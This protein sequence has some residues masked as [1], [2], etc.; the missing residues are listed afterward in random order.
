M[1]LSSSTF[2]LM[3]E[4]AF[5]AIAMAAV[6]AFGVPFLLERG[7]VSPALLMRWSW[8]AAI[9]VALLLSAW[10]ILRSDARSKR[11]LIAVVR[12]WNRIFVRRPIAPDPLLSR[13][14]GFRQNVA[15]Y[16]HV[17]LP[18]FL[19]AA[20]GRVFLDVATLGACFQLFGGGV[21]WA[22]VLTGY[23]LIL[24]LSGV[25]AL[26]GGLG[27]ADLS[28]P[29]VFSRLGAPAPVA[30]AG[31]LTYRLIAFWMVRLLGFVA[32]QVEEARR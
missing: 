6:A 29:V 26:P 2:T 22:T 11:A 24:L 3:I 15:A 27:L 20:F 8:I 21:G 12:L 10:W 9:L 4:T 19:L 1:P 5:L 13:L 30:L 31:G 25:A 28:V 18:G 17:P 7:A 32:W 23:G 14:A 16:R